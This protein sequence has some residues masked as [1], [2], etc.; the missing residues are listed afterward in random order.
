MRT[1][2]AICGAAL[3]LA[4][5]QA[6]A[7]DWPQFRGPRGSGISSERHAPLNW[8]AATNVRWRAPLPAPGNSSPIVS[9]GRVFVT[10]ATDAG[11]QRHL[12]CFDAQT[13]ELRWDR[14]VEFAGD[15]PTHSTNPAC[16]STPAADGQRVIVWHGSAGLFCYDYDGAELWRRD[17]GTFRHIW[18]F[19]SSPSLYGDVVILNCGPGE[20]T[21]VTAINRTTGNPLWQT[22][23]PGGASGEQEPAAG[24]KPD[25]IGSWS[26]PV[27]VTVDGRPQALVSLPHHVQAYDVDTGAV[28]WKV[29]G[30]G[31]LVYTSVMPG[32]GVAVAMGGYSGPAIG[33]R[34]GG[35][36]DVTDSNR[37][38]R[39]HERN[40]QRIGSG[41]IHQGRLFMANE[42]GIGQCLDVTTGD[43]LWRARLPGGKIWGSMV[44]AADRLYVTNQ[45]GTTLV[46]APNAEKLEVLA[47]NPLGEP[48]NS[49][50]AV[51]EGR[52]YLRTFA[53]LYCIADTP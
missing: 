26:T 48:S 43:E 18:G 23:E 10:V 38:W 39:Q 4:A 3:C 9:R 21:F 37:L 22:D 8:D 35:S 27:I 31:D 41:V 47:E 53:G 2:V 24:E 36:G 5:A 34:L 45:D 19:G 33:F 1:Q 12:M 25:W 16:A 6:A 42:P 51:A 11:R 30:L 50:P 15:E 32:D 46:L 20:R 28:A 44:L 7:E 52:I 40:P 17:L 49:T 29:D 13:G 14:V